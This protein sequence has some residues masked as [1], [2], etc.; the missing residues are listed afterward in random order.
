MGNGGETFE[1]PTPKNEKGGSELPPSL[2][3]N[4]GNFDFR[5]SFS[6]RLLLFQK[7]L[8]PVSGILPEIVVVKRI[9]EAMVDSPSECCG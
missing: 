3:L 7:L 2:N 4:P 1:A 6:Y 5:I 8:Y 9:V